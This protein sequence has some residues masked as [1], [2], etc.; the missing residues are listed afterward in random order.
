[1][2]FPPVSRARRA[3][4][5]G[6]ATLTGMKRWVILA[7]L[8]IA[9]T[10]GWFDA[11][12]AEEANKQ[13]RYV[14]ASALLSDRKAV[15][16]TRLF[17]IDLAFANPADLE[18]RTTQMKAKLERELTEHIT[19]KMHREV[20]SVTTVC[21]SNRFGVREKRDGEISARR[22]GGKMRTIFLNGFDFSLREGK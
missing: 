5:S 3:I 17:T 14:Y 4:V 18:A 15:V 9:A 19:S 8:V 7:G 20:V 12:A 6:S 11:L 13:T 1:M 10:A 16:I 21:D 2:K 22:V